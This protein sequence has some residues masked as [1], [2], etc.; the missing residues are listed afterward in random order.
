MSLYN[1]NDIAFNLKSEDYFIQRPHHSFFNKIFYSKL[2]RSIVPF[3]EKRDLTILDRQRGSEWYGSAP[4]ATWVDGVIDYT[5]NKHNINSIGHFHMHENR[6]NKPQKARENG[7]DA[8]HGM[9]LYP[10]YSPVYF[11][12]GCKREINNYKQCRSS[13]SNDCTEQKVN[14]V[15]VC[16]KWCLELMREKKK[17]FMKATVIDNNTY[18]EAMRV[19]DYNQGRSLK[20]LKDK[21]AHLRTIRRD[22]YWADDRYNPT[23]YP[24]PDHNSNVVLG[25]KIVFSDVL[26]GNRVELIQND[27]KDAMNNV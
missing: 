22:G 12:K 16:P 26:G 20:D 18:R 24:S 8:T 11:P 27:R 7:G 9:P 19:E 6:K 14:V 13:G 21:N 17:F 15:E 3:H 10:V 23:L 1:V 2:W 25:D 5:Y 4:Q